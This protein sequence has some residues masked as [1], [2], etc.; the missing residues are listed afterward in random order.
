MTLHDFRRLF[1]PFGVDRN[2]T[3]SFSAFN[4]DPRRHADSVGSSTVDLSWM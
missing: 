3:D 1:V 2:A 4:G